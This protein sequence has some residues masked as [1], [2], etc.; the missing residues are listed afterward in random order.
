MDLPTAVRE[1]L[2][3]LQPTEPPQRDPLSRKTSVLEDLSPRV[4]PIDPFQIP[5]DFEPRP[6]QIEAVD[7]WSRDGRGSEMATGTGKTLTAL[8]AAHRALA[9]SQGAVLVIAAPYIHLVDQWVGE[10]RRFGL[11]PIAGYGSAH[12]WSRDL[13]DEVDL[14]RVGAV[15]LASCVVTHRALRSPAL[16]SALERAG[17]AT[18]MLV[19]D[20]VHHRGSP[21]CSLACRHLHSTCA[22]GS[23]RPHSRWLDEQGNEL[24]ESYFGAVV[25]SLSLPRAI[26]LGYL[27]PYEY[28][29]VIVELEQHELETYLLVTRQ[30]ARALGGG[31]SLQDLGPLLRRR[32]EVLN[33]AAGKLA[34]LRDLLPPGSGASHAL[35]YTSPSRL[36]PS[37]ELLAAHSK[38]RV[39]RFTF[40]EDRENAPTTLG[41]VR[42][43]RPSG[44][45]SDSTLG[46]RPRCSIYPARPSCLQAVATRANS[47]SA[48]AASFERRPTKEA[49]VIFDLITVPPEHAGSDTWETE[50]A[51]VRRELL[52]FVEFADHARNAQTARQLLMPLQHRYHLLDM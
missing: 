30:I 34:A 41:E 18:L 19:A 46:R 3:E 1:R 48:G 2:I 50:R 9:S 17:S 40:R 52:R 36:R 38:L 20:E 6:Y 33:G 42:G 37:L 22:S 31:A 23:V 25:F 24:I 21:T 16:R 39:H 28:R 51:L 12:R 43:W 7:A 11:R 5:L 45:C 44:S 27:T 4:E 29:P 26:E 13:R 35:V 47:C 8:L 10:L 15:S 32:S 49:A 14:V